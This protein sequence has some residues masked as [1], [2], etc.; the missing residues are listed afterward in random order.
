M[1]IVELDIKGKII[2]H[3]WRYGSRYDSN[4]TCYGSFM[5]PPAPE[6]K[7]NSYFK[8]FLTDD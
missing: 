5:P 3:V 4:K 2:K 7:K 8:R 1:D 6:K